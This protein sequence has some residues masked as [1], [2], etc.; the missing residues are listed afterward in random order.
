[1]VLDALCGASNAVYRDERYGSV[2]EIKHAG[3]I[4]ILLKPNTYMNLSGKA[5]RY[6][7]EIEKIPLDRILVITDDIALPVGKIR[8]KP[9]GSDGGH[10]G[11]K[12]IQNLL[13]TQNFARLRFGVGNNYMKGKQ[14]DYVLAPF[15]ADETEII[16]NSVKKSFE[17]IFQYVTIGIER[18]MNNVN[19]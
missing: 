7:M 4:L 8:L 17:A 1:M 5:V 15:D 3:R 13:L 9:S 11:L 16:E 10:N 12:S 6:W 19:R 18:T 14:A 2:C